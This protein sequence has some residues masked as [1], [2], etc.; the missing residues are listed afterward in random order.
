M[1]SVIIMDKATTRLHAK[2]AKAAKA[3]E[4]Q[5]DNLRTEVAGIASGKFYAHRKEGEKSQTFQAVTQAQ[6][7]ALE[8][9][10]EAI[11]NLSRCWLLLDAEKGE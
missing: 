5:A 7:D 1:T 11:V 4:K 9:T 10:V 6:L 8:A 2:I 3:L